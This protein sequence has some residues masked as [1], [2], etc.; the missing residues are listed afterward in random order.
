MTAGVV[1]AGGSGALGCVA[2]EGPGRDMWVMEK[3]LCECTLRQHFSGP[4]APAVCTGPLLRL[5]PEEED[6]LVRETPAHTGN[7][8]TSL[9]SSENQRGLSPGPLFKVYPCYLTMNPLRMTDSWALWWIKWCPLV[10]YS[11]DKTYL[12][13]QRPRDPSVC[14]C[15]CVLIAQ[16]CLTLCDPMDQSPPGSSVHGILQ[17][18]ILE[19]VAISFY[20]GSSQSRD[21]TWVSCITGRLFTIW[22][23]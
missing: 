13:I 18:R 5:C 22:T 20:R 19:W 2:G 4:P 23:N 16:W 3:W 7:S 17:A 10:G 21:G 6:G 11:T 15:V 8:V 1:S 9:L 12:P 14:V